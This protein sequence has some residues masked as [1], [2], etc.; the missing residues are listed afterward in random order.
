MLLYYL[1]FKVV[2]VVASQLQL[3]PSVVLNSNASVNNWNTLCVIATEHLLT[4]KYKSNNL[5]AYSQVVMTHLVTKA[6]SLIVLI[7]CA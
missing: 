2:Q 5:L 1:I 4:T 7:C 3:E 6:T